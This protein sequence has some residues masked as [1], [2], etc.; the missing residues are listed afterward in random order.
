[1]DNIARNRGL[2][3]AARSEN[4]ESVDL[5]VSPKFDPQLIPASP[6]LSFELSLWSSGFK[7]VAGLDEAG[8]GALAGPVA[9]A[10]VI[11]PERMELL[12]SLH[13]VRDSKQMTPSQ[14]E[15]WAER[16]RIQA[17]CAG[18]GFA[19][20][21]EIDDRG[22]VP[23]TRLAMQ[24]ALNQLSISPQHLLLDFLDLPDLPVPQ[25][26]LVKGDR[27]SLSI[28]AASVLA[29][30]ARDELMRRLDVQY[31]GYGFAVNKGY[32]TLAHREMLQSLGPSPVHRT[33]FHLKN[34]Q[35]PNF[36]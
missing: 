28:A 27:R 8:R 23:A 10:A 34:T 19:S 12:T 25:T 32:G 7:F 1:M 21:L 26:C 36:R 14:R 17:L 35:S 22:I 3:R 2:R 6:D 18:V 9:A 15:V 16:L 13:G 30:T 33:T 31:P 4:S 5:V 20:H 11:L 29:K 24:R